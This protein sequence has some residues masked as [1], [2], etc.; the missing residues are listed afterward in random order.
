MKIVSFEICPF[1]ERVRAMLQAKN[2]PYDIDYI[3]LSNKPDWFLEVSPNGQVPILITDDNQV[4]FESD[5]IVEYLDE[6]FGTPLSSEDPVQKAQDR[7]WSY[8]ASKNYLV[9]CSAQRSPDAPTLD[10]RAAKLS[11]ALQ[12]IETR[13]EASRY[14]NGDALGMVDIA[15]LP[16]LHR[17]SLIERQSGYDFLQ[18]FPKVKRWQRDLLAT[19]IA[20]T[21]VSDDFI[22]RFNAFYLA[23]STFLGQLAKDKNGM[24]CCGPAVCTVG[25][26]ACCA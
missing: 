21:S 23:E 26:I 18:G 17:A 7:A 20:E 22:A 12:K 19:G 24:A 6:V 16:L 8:L 9:Q 2:V 13:L 10:E 15:W 1:V 14:A 3:D 25:D 5:A 4:L 11:T